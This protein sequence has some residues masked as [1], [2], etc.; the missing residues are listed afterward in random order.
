[1]SDYVFISYSQSDALKAKE[2]ADVLIEKG[3]SIWI[4]YINLANLQVDDDEDEITEKAVLSSK[5]VAIITSPHALNDSLLKDE[6]KF[7]RDHGKE[8]VLVKVAPCDINKKMRWRRL[9][10]IDLINDRTQGIESL[11]NKIGDSAISPPEPKKTV[12]VAENIKV[13]N[14]PTLDINKSDL[15]ETATD[16]LISEDN[17]SDKLAAMLQELREDIKLYESTINSQIKSSYLGVKL[18][19]ACSVLLLLGLY[20]IPD[21]KA[22]LDEGEAKLK[23][24]SPI[25]GIIPSSLSSFSLNKIKEKKKRLLSLKTCDRK[26]SRMEHGLIKYSKGDILG[27]EDEV[28]NYINA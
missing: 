8:V 22:V 13:Q 1:M 10:C 5:F 23:Y 25:G 28:F 26:L 16:N 3:K 2:L 27:L 21:L 6:K 11:L 7:A 17:S 4:D 9:K 24:L 12:P 20:L 19:I 15:A 18:L 14:E